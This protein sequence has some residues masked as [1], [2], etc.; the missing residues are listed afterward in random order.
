MQ[1]GYLAETNIDSTIYSG[2]SV[3]NAIKE[4]QSFVGLDATGILDE[5]T[6]NLMSMPRCG[7]K[8][9]IISTLTDKVDEIDEIDKVDE[10]NEVDNADV[11]SKVK[12]YVT[13]GK[14]Y[15][16]KIEN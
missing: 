15:L 8:D 10:V 13:Q 12:R 16:Y 6:L 1:F 7:I 14:F 11:H 2:E 9:K 3:A 4:F 5:D